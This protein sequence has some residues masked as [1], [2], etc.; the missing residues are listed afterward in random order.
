MVSSDFP[1]G[2]ITATLKEAGL[3]VNDF[4]LRTMAAWA[5]STPMLSYTN[6]PIGMPAVKGKTLELMRTGYAMFVTMGDFRKAFADL[7]TSHGGQA[8][9]DA[10]ALDERYSKAYRAIHALKWPASTTETDW[11]SAVLDLTS[12][13]Y[14]SKVASVASPTDRKTS[15][16]LGT[17]T[18]FGTS[19]A[20]TGRRAAE[21]FAAIQQ[22]TQAF[23]SNMR[24]RQSNG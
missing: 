16:T 13:S 5:D 8:L 20:Y 3:P 19:A 24:R 1:D 18:A 15:G 21:T 2:W 17:Q 22:A 6:N 14:R 10:L 12:E 9:R 7:I 11:P 4:T 23:Q